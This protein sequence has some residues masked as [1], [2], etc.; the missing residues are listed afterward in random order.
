LLSRAP[1]RSTRGSSCRAGGDRVEYC[2][3]VVVHE[4]GREGAPYPSAAKCYSATLF[5]ICPDCAQTAPPPPLQDLPSADLSFCR[6]HSFGPRTLRSESTWRRVLTSR[7]REVSVPPAGTPAS[8][9][10]R[11]DHHGIHLATLSARTS[12]G[13]FLFRYNS[14]L[15]LAQ[16]DPT[17]ESFEL[18]ISSYCCTLASGGA[19]SE[20]C[21]APASL[22]LQHLRNPLCTTSRSAPTAGLFYVHE[23]VQ[24]QI[25]EHGILET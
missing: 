20:C 16:A 15:T 18:Q 6:A 17:A 11:I 1:T 7:E 21:R 14:R 19:Q 23:L 8:R 24:E 22:A 25:Q 2:L 4:R 12:R 3:A 13:P 5:V 9:R 10:T